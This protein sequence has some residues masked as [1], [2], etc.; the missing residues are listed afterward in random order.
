MRSCLSTGIWEALACPS[1]PAC[2]YSTQC[3]TITVTFIKQKFCSHSFWFHSA[4][5]ELGK[6]QKLFGSYSKF[7]YITLTTDFHFY[8]VI[9]ARFRVLFHIKTGQTSL[10][11]RR[12]LS[13]SL[14]LRQEENSLEHSQSQ[15]SSPSWR[16]LQT[17]WNQGLYWFSSSLTDNYRVNLFYGLNHVS[18]HLLSLTNSFLSIK[19]NI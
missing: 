12:C 2:V 17:I 3:F 5:K 7:H 13:R 1:L 8:V 4:A 14:N 6:Q 16:S 9:A 19:K 11:Q 18:V 10:S 15:R